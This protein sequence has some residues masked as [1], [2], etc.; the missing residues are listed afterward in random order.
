VRIGSRTRFGALASPQASA[1]VGSI[2]SAGGTKL[3]GRLIKAS[4]PLESGLV[5]GTDVRGDPPSLST[6]G[7][8]ANAP[9]RFLSPVSPVDLAA[10][11]ESDEGIEVSRQAIWKRFRPS[12][13]TF[14]QS[15]L[16]RA[17][18]SRSGADA[19]WEGRFGRLLLQDSTVVRLPLRLFG[20]YSGVPNAHQAVCNAR[21]QVVY[22]VLAGQFVSFSIDPYSILSHQTLQMVENHACF[23][24]AGW[25]K[26]S[27]SSLKQILF[28]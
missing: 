26:D 7:Q 11:M 12:C 1:L 10:R 22:D 17:I 16:T 20:E 2:A 4:R 14:L 24:Q 8:A 27:P 28:L 19:E 13:E 23:E 9:G 3:I 21:I 6:A 18:G 5:G 15:I 25:T